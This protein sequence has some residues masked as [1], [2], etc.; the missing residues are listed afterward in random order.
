MGKHLEASNMGGLYH[1]RPEQEGEGGFPRTS[2]SCRCEGAGVGLEVQPP[3]P[4]SSGRGE[5]RGGA[6]NLL[7][8][9]LLT[10]GQCI[11]WAGP[12]RCPSYRQHHRAETGLEGP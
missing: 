7:S 8:F 4:E 11:W 12:R 5:R 9:H 6:L 3:G 1:P 10:A 2:R